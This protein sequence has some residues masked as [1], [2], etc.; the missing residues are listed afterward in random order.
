MDHCF[1]RLLEGTGT[2]ISGWLARSRSPTATLGAGR[3]VCTLRSEVR[4]LWFVGLG[5]SGHEILLHAIPSR[6]FFT[7]A[8]RAG[9]GSR[10]QVDDLPVFVRG[11][12]CFGF[13][14]RGAWYCHDVMVYI[15]MVSG[16]AVSDTILPPFL[17]L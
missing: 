12:Y 16:N 9:A 1:G 14:G 6:R 17:V 7:T 13:N 10:P 2:P 15:I 4:A 3:R 5:V 11:G 8:G